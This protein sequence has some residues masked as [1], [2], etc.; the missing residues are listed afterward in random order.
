MSL[1]SHLSD[2]ESPVRRF[3][4]ECAPQLALAGTRGAEGK[5]FASQF[6]FDDLTAL[7]NQ[8]PIPDDVK[9]RT[10]H[11]VVAGMALDYRLRMDLPGFD[12]T[13]TVAQIGL[14]RLAADPGL[15]HRGQHIHKLLQE[16]LSL[17]YLT[18]QDADSQPL[19]L[20]RAAVPLA[21]CESIVRAGT[22]VALSGDLGRQIKRAKTSID[23]MM[24]IDSSLIFDIAVLHKTVSPALAEWNQNIA[25]GAT[26]VPN[27]R[28]LGS[29]AVGGADADWAIGDTLVD[30][31]A[32]EKITNPWIR[33][34]LF[35]LLGYALL[36][37][38]DSLGIR[39]VAILLPR[40]PHFT[41]WTVDDLLGRDAE[42]ALPELREEFAVLL[43]E[44]L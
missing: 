1:T 2:V 19:S 40:Q 10:G 16:S 6:G 35:Q 31:K 21:W 25:E 38:D 37:L 15:V 29:S 18:V 22:Q 23:L 17:S 8:R 20:A 5:V 32:R 39:K 4:Y 7:A 9:N 3:I 43:A 28:F 14:D 34:A 27:P 41:V 13:K 36:D 42:V 30:L 11:A 26:Y 12:F 24:S 44:M 33:D